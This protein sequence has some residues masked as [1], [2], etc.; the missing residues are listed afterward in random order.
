[1]STTI[2]FKTHR[3]IGDN[4][5]LGKAH[6]VSVECPECAASIL[7]MHS[8]KVREL[9]GVATVD[10]ISDVYGEDTYTEINLYLPAGTEF[11]Y[12]VSVWEPQ[13]VEEARLRVVACAVCSGRVS[14]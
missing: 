5:L 2:T 10:T 14:L 8:R 9:G 7:I 12:F 3:S 4:F 6:S 11:Q 13:V 1:M